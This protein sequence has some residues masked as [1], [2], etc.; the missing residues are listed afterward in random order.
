MKKILLIL[1]TCFI[2]TGI[3]A[4]AETVPYG[5]LVNID[6]E[7]D[8]YN[9]YISDNNLSQYDSRKLKSLKRVTFDDLDTMLLALENDRICY[10]WAPG[11]MARYIADRNKNLKVVSSPTLAAYYSMATRKDD[12]EL[13]EQI[14]TAL[15]DIRN[16]G[17]LNTLVQK[18]IIS[19]ERNTVLP[20]ATAGKPKIVVGVTG[21]MPTFDYVD[22]SGIPAGFNVALMTEVA[23][24]T[25]S[26]V[27]F[28]NVGWGS[29]LVALSSKRIDVLFCFEN[30]ANLIGPSIGGTLLITRPYYHDEQ[31]IVYNTRSKKVSLFKK[32]FKSLMGYK[33][34]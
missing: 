1:C 15:I 22:E 4:A 16:D 29:K 31:C 10:M 24:R 13:Y 28:V 34:D 8:A 18:Y 9:K 33:L 3:L 32:V 23:R 21:N 17:T 20:K 2:C 14:N 5:S 27:S 12:K 19:G 25:D 30:Y 7:E 6:E 11:V 26:N